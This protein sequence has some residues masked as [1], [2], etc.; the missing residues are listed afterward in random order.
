MWL[1]LLAH[2][3]KYFELLLIAAILLKLFFFYGAFGGG[4]G[5]IGIFYAIFKWFSGNE[6]DMAENENEKKWMLV[7]NLISL[8]VYLL[9]LI[10]IVSISFVELLKN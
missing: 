2:Y 9:L 6:R 1:Q 10:I 7:S 4:N 3:N 8:M 5:F